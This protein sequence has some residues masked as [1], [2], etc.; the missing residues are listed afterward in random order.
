MK[1]ALLY[2][3]LDG[4]SVHCQLCA[5]SCKIPEGKFGFCGVRQNIE[6]ILYSHNYGKLVA[7][8]VD[9]VEKKPLYHFLPGTTTFSI[10]SAGC[11]F[12]CGFCQNWQISQLGPRSLTLTGTALDK[13]LNV[14]D[15]LKQY[16]G[17]DFSADKV[18]KLAKQNN[19]KSIAYTYTEPTIYFEFA[20]EAAILAKKAGLAN[21]F[22]TNGYMSL[23]AISLLKPYLDAANVDLK[24]YKESSY[25]KICAAKLAP[26]LD[27]IRRLHAAGV[28]VEIT[29][30]VIPGE[31]DSPEELSGIAKFIAGISKDIPWHISAF[32]ADY[33]FISYP[34]TPEHALKL[35]YDLGKNCGLGYV[36]AGNVYGWGQDTSCG[37][38]QRV[39]IKREGFDITASHLTGNKCVFCQAALPGVFSPG[40]V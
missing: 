4:L 14:L 30:L 7:V 31:N 8:N 12:R 27:S 19:C 13:R 9:P 36:Y 22:V 5:H 21:I 23:Q 37:R 18:V 15:F 39:L 24:F 33:K 38:C 2:T 10:A 40:L 11:N 34:N 26:V 1:E 6:G 35:A 25:Q 3:R 29:T 20:L 16:P 32:H 28:W 17:E